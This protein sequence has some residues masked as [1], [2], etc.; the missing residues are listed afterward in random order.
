MTA[1]Y[2]SLDIV[3]ALSGLTTTEISDDNLSSLMSIAVGLFNSEVNII[4]GGADEEY[5]ELTPMADDDTGLIY[6]TKHFPIGDLNGDATVTTTDIEVFN[7]L[8]QE[9]PTTQTV[10][11]IDAIKG[12]V[13]LAT[14]PTELVYAYYAYIPFD[15]NSQEFIMAYAYL[16]AKIAWDRVIGTAIS[17]SIGSF[18]VQRSNYFAKCYKDALNKLQGG[19]G[20]MCDVS[21]STAKMPSMKMNPQ[22]WDEGRQS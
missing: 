3:R 12:I 21:P 16:C 10:S 13:T 4:V 22:G 20:S 6:T 5:E 11:S 8:K 15:V 9:N 19:G 18:S 17:T 1:Q 7:G 2:C 14:A